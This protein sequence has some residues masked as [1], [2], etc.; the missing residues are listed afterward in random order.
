MK[1]ESLA[2]PLTAFLLF[3]VSH[4]MQVAYV[5]DLLIIKKR[6]QLQRTSPRNIFLNTVLFNQC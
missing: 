5:N 4:Y 6:L 3:Y 2:V 1:L